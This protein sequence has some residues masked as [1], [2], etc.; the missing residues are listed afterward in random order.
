MEGVHSENYESKNTKRPTKGNGTLK[1][2]I[3]M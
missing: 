3:N 2:T 1:N